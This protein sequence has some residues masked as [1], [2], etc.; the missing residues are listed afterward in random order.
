MNNDEEVT[1]QKK[2]DEEFTTAMNNP[3]LQRIYA[4]GFICGIGTG[5]IG[6]IFKNGNLHVG[7][8][9]LSYTVAKTLAIKLGQIIAD[10]ES[11]TGN[12]IMITDKIASDMFKGV[13]K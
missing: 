4:N 11:K 5:D 1:K 12:E 10:L 3:N 8:L 6:I 2:L 9:N 7:A 13:K